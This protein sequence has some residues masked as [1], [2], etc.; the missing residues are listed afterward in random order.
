MTVKAKNPMIS[1]L[2][3][4]FVTVSKLS[5]GQTCGQFFHYPCAEVKT[6]TISTLR[7]NHLPAPFAR[8]IPADVSAGMRASLYRMPASCPHRFH[9]S[10]VTVARHQETD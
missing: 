4:N 9:E 6:L 10:T 2:R 1:M 3:A 7:A 8:K 5:C